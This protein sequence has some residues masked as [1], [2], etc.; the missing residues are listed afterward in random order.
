MKTSLRLL[1]NVKAY[2]PP[3]DFYRA[4]LP[5]MPSPRGGGWRD[6]GLCVFHAD[7]HAGSFRVN[8]ETGAFCCF[9]CGAKGS[10]IIAFIQQRDGLS[11]PEALQQLADEWGM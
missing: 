8:L 11:F 5:T 7:N 2:I 6:G 1:E 4:E 3:A 9:S 10:D